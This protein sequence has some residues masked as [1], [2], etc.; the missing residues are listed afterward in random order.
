MPLGWQAAA[1]L[2]PTSMSGTGRVPIIVLGIVAAL[3]GCTIPIRPGR[4]ATIVD[5]EVSGVVAA[6]TRVP[7]SQTSYRLDVGSQE[8]T[9]DT[10]DTQKLYSGFPEGGV[11]LYGTYPRSWYIGTSPPHDG[12]YVVT[13]GYAFDDP[14]AVILVFDELGTGIGI[15]IPKAPGFDPGSALSHYGPSEGQYISLGAPSFCLDA[16]GR[17]AWS[18]SAWPPPTASP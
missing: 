15:R 8:I 9:L 10:K 3:V 17:M 18:T 5:P 7:G 1:R 6:A 16:R 4:P 2:G 12:C 14:D 13:A 11:V